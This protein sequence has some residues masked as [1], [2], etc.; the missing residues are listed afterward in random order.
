MKTILSLVCTLAFFC[1]ATLADPPAT[2][3]TDAKSAAAIKAAT[4]NAQPSQPK[5]TLAN[6]PYGK[7]ERQVLDFYKAKS[8][9]P[10][11]VVFYIHGGWVNGDKARVNGAAYLAAGISM[12]AINYH[13]IAQAEA[14]GVQ[15]PVKGSLHDA[16][17]ALQFV[18]SKAA[19]WNIDQKDP[20]HTANFGVKL[21]EK[22]K[23]VGVECELMYP[24]A[25]DVKHQTPQQ[26]LIEKL[27]APRK[28]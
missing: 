11:P 22:F 25:P 9:T 21:Q 7:H 6:V 28:S 12:V 8:D 14:D 2:A 13:Y 16:A 3:K 15:P 1:G 5:P 18:R 23:S 10:T 26:Y 17:R 20:T 4:K 19:E 27:K 24:G